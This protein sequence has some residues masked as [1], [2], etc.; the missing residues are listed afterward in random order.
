MNLFK[1]SRYGKLK[2]KRYKV[3]ELSSYIDMYYLK[4]LVFL[5][6]SLCIDKKT[7][8]SPEWIPSKIETSSSQQRAT[9]ISRNRHDYRE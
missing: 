3:D 6:A 8:L 5:F 2:K 4:I 9:F 7:L 1:C